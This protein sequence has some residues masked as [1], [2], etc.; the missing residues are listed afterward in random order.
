MP[1]TEENP[2]PTPP[3]GGAPD[4]PLLR[5]KRAFW[6]RVGGEG[7]IASVIVHVALILIAVAWVVSTI[8]DNA[9]QK[10]PNTF[11]TGA[12]GGSGGQTAKQ[13]KTKTVPKNIKSLAKANSRI[14]SKN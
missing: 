2:A 6:R 13:F 5:P 10:D 11:A 12:G 1:P 9:G 8:T 14:T 7:L 3:S 4:G